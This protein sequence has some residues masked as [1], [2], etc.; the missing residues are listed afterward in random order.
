MCVCRIRQAMRPAMKPRIIY[1]MMCNIGSVGRRVFNF[2]SAEIAEP[3]HVS[4][5]PTFADS[6]TG[7]SVIARIQQLFQYSCESVAIAFAYGR[8]SLLLC[9][10]SVICGQNKRRSGYL[11][12]SGPNVISANQFDTNKSTDL[13]LVWSLQVHYTGIGFATLRVIDRTVC[14]V[15]VTFLRKATYKYKPDDRM[16]AFRWIRIVNIG[17]LFPFAGLRLAQSHDLGTQF[18]ITFEH[19]KGGVFTLPESNRGLSIGCMNCGRSKPGSYQR[20]DQIPKSRGFHI[21]TD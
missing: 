5:S 14:P 1:Q 10:L 15:S 13:D 3:D 8:S 18:A 4:I 9:A 19:L 6:F 12:H 17:F 21:R 11:V 2:G 20:Q 7:P 16:A